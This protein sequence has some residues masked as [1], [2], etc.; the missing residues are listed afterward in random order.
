MVNSSRSEKDP[1]AEANQASINLTNLSKQAKYSEGKIAV[2]DAV[3][4]DPA[5]NKKEHAVAFGKDANGNIIR[6]DVNTGT[7]NNG[8]IPS[9]SNRFADLHN[10]TDNKP[11][12]SGDLYGF[13]DIATDMPGYSRSIITLNGAVYS[14]ALI[15]KQ[16]AIN[17]NS[18]YPRVPGI[19]VPNSDSTVT[20]YEPTFPQDLVDEY[21][22]VK[23]YS[24]GSDE[25]A[26]AFILSKY[27]SGVALMKQD[28]NGNFKR[29]NTKEHTDANGNK[30]YTSNN[31]Q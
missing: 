17:F 28:A 31:C 12:S 8:T 29:L 1:C 6:S 5:N 3:A 14:L 18:N 10:H 4:N 24:G 23:Y 21:I 20:K 19:M 25:I 30:T 13:I 22:D 16:A 7:I 9:V 26:T 2:Q 11:P 15:D 27:N